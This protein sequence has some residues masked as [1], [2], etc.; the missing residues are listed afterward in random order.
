MR[1]DICYLGQ[2]H[3]N[4]LCHRPILINYVRTRYYLD[5]NS[6]LNCQDDHAR[7][8]NRTHPRT[9]TDTLTNIPIYRQLEPGMRAECKDHWATFVCG[10]Q[11]LFELVCLISLW[12]TPSAQPLPRPVTCCPVLPLLPLMS[13]GQQ[14]NHSKGI[15][16]FALW[17]PAAKRIIE[18]FY[19]AKR[20]MIRSIVQEEWGGRSRTN[21]NEKWGYIW[22]MPA[23][24]KRCR[25]KRVHGDF[26]YISCLYFQVFVLF[27]EIFLFLVSFWLFF[28]FP[29]VLFQFFQLS[30]CCVW[31]FSATYNLN[32]FVLVPW[33]V[34]IEDSLRLVF[35]DFLL[36]V[37]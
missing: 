31:Y 12:G 32:A 33:R 15:K 23:M 21:G 18:K 22:N 36:V 4:Q 3:C 37:V 10:R 2:K 5:S 29:Y 26:S 30:L 11:L 9:H 16:K 28:Y 8:A 1:L 19:N 20:M 24:L 6:L 13:V 25:M 14:A 35:C 17:F 34:P 7:S 27:L